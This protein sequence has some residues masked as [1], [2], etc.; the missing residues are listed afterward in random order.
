MN[1]EIEIRTVTLEAIETREEADGSH[2]VG[3]VTPFHSTFD[4]GGYLEIIG[5]NAFDKSIQ[6]RQQ[7]IPLL[8]Q[9]NRQAHPIGMSAS[10]EKTSDGLIADFRLASTPRAEESK[11]LAREGIVTGLSVGFIPIRNKTEVRKSD[12]RKVI[13]RVE[14]R[15]DHVGLV[16]N[17]AYSE[18]RV[19]SVRSF[20]PDDPVVVPRLSKWR[21]LIDDKK[22]IE[23]RQTS[24]KPNAGM[25]EEAK[26]GLAWRQEHGRGGT[27]VGVARARDIANGKNLSADT[28]GRMFSFFSRHEKASK[29]GQGFK[30]GQDG[31][32][33]AGRIAWALWGG[34]AGFAWSRK[35]RNQLRD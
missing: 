17:P 16:T 12:G 9:H 30:Q 22:K 11:T 15:L 5:R 32:P 2:L 14:A 28:V 6:E 8:E 19:V 23:D 26:R 10:W 3:I 4:A 7:Q 1:P 18:A 31:Y 13:T 33:S 27:A 21:H 25:I 20:D 24:Y 34:D 29:G 35:I